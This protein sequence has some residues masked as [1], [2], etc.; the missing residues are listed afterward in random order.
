MNSKGWNESGT[1]R[2][3]DYSRH[4]PFRSPLLVADIFLAYVQFLVS[5][6]RMMNRR[7]VPRKSAETENVPSPSLPIRF[8]RSR[9]K[10]FSLRL[11]LDCLS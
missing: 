5:R 11:A 7:V 4:S 10:R 3:S 1:I 6:S 9:L 2:W 8:A